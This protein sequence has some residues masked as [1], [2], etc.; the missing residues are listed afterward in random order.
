MNRLLFI[1]ATAA[2]ATA[3]AWTTSAADVPS[4]VQAGSP[5]TP[6]TIEN[7]KATRAGMNQ[8]N[9]SWI[10]SGHGGFTVQSVTIHRTG[11]NPQGKTYKLGPV[12]RWSDWNATP[13]VQYRYS[14]CATDSGHQTACA[15]VEYRLQQ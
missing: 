4:N 12:S 2:V 3:T 5:H 14:V 11:T 15:Y 9:L 7:L 8:I 10:M 13:N 1:L 6:P